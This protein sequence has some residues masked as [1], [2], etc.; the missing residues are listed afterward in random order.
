MS[1]HKRKELVQDFVSRIRRKVKDIKTLRG[2]LSKVQITRYFIQG[3]PSA[4]NLWKPILQS[5]QSSFLRV[6]A[7]A[8]TAKVHLKEEAL[9]KKGS[10][11]QSN[12]PRRAI[13]AQSS[14]NNSKNSQNRNKSNNN[15]PRKKYTHNPNKYYAVHKANS[16]NTKDCNTLKLV[17]N[18]D[19]TSGSSSKPSNSSSK[20]TFTGPKL[21]RKQYIVKHISPNQVRCFATASSIPTDQRYHNTSKWFI[22]SGASD[23]FTG[24][25]KSF[26]SFKEISP[27]PI[28]LGDNS[29]VYVT[30]KGT[31]KL[32]LD[33][34][35]ILHLKDVL[36]SPHFGDNN[37]LSIPKFITIGYIVTFQDHQVFIRDRNNNI[38]SSTLC[39]KAG[40]YALDQRSSMALKVLKKPYTESLELWH[41]RYGHIN[42]GYIRETAYIVS[43]LHFLSTKVESPCDPCELGKST[44][45]S[46]YPKEDPPGVLDILTINI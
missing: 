32:N 16:H 41:R 14:Q 22:N 2:S 44:R 6:K 30:G 1:L 35:Q 10:K 8:L 12:N 34:G 27:F 18:Y 13:Q 4:Y 36:Y 42:Y 3:L 33:N 20:D 28:T 40:L 17:R 45:S 31:L 29:I 9:K 24:S 19:S 37:L 26:L 39:P 15:T 43:G 23:H 11:D 46:I 38:A 21:D 5:N 7:K 25:N